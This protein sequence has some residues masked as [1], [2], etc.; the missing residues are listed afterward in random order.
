M[1]H[2]LQF[3]KNEFL[4]VKKKYFLPSLLSLTIENLDKNKDNI[5]WCCYSRQA[6]YNYSLNFNFQNIIL[7]Q[8]ISP[9]LEKK[10]NQ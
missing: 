7:Y 1:N 10:K 6:G 4:N 2:D 8:Y 9:H 5:L 3:Y